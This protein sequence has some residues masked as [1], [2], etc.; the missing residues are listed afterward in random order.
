[1]L[2]KAVEQ[3]AVLL[4]K[5]ANG[6][7]QYKLG[8]TISFRKVKEEAK[9]S[10]P[11]PP[12]T[13][14]CDI[15]QDNSSCLLPVPPCCDDPSVQSFAHITH[16]ATP[17]VRGRSSAGIENISWKHHE[18]CEVRLPTQDEDVA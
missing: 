15:Q 7:K 6:G 9:H 10:E 5:Y 12:S 17:C 2:D 3:P 14:N 11:V 8:I 13:Y 16:A 18:L 1:M 4:H